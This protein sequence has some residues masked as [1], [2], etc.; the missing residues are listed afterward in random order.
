MSTLT[1]ILRR[2][3]HITDADIERIGAHS[4]RHRCAPFVSVVELGLADEDTLVRVLSGRLM[5]PIASAEVLRKVERET[6][7]HVPAEL[8]WSGGVLPV[9]VDDAGNLTLAMA[10]PTDERAV[11]AI[12]DHT[13]MYLL[14]AVAP[15]GPLRA[16]VKRCYGARVRP[17]K[18]PPTPL[19]MPA[20][21]TEPKAPPPQAAPPAPASA[22]VTAPPAP[23]RPA[24]APA[25]A[26]PGP[27]RRQ[28]TMPRYGASS[29]SQLPAS[30][31]LSPASFTEML[32]RLVE[33]SDRDAIMAVLLDFLAD[34][35]ERVI[36]FIHLRDEL[37]GRD[38]R[39]SD[40]VPEAVAQVRIPTTGP[41]VFSDVIHGARVHFGP[42]PSSR[43]IDAAFD[44]AMGGI[45]GNVLVL[46]VKVRDKVPVLVF[47]SGASSLVDP[48]SLTQLVSGVQTALERLI[49]RRKSMDV[50][51]A[52]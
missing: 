31:P 1:T 2:A 36:L 13:G 45:K 43:V 40:L 52:R 26:A 42:W 38:A 3:G 33:A 14:R 28:Q 44:K 25:V 47:A 32:P 39:G 19:E 30:A 9:S 49:F 22:V 50:P 48:R 27:S 17:T 6:L 7:K 5:V 16:A 20:V 41:S 29:P 8:A 23:A 18:G 11:H 15:V 12:A 51:R 34:G 37:K 35:F 21:D 10:D 4:R 46:P 24:P